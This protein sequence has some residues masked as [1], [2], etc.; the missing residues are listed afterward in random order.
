MKYCPA[1]KEIK[2]VHEFGSNRSNKSGLANHCRPCHSKVMAAGKRRKHGSERNYLLKLRYGVTEEEVEQMIAEQGGICVIC[3][4]DEPKHV[5]HDHMTGLVR[6]VLCFKCNGALGQFE[7][8]PERLRLAAEYLELDGSHARRLEL[9]TGA[10]VFGGP[11]R[12]SSDPN[13]R[14]PS[15]MAGTGRH[16]HLRRRYGIND[17]DAQWLLKM[18]VGYCAACFDYP[19]EHVD[20][21]HRTGAVRGI[22]CHGCNTGMGQLRDDPVA[23]RRAADYLT[24][25]LVKTVP[26]EDGGTRLSFTVPDIDPLNV[27]PG[28]WTVHWEADGRHRKAN[29]EFGVLI[30][31]PAWTG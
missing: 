15:P 12:V 28:G 29:P 31:G 18:Q 17:A 26:A 25:G 7:D 4:R 2:A 9:E 14:K 8:N 20:H 11:D 19:A 5:D 16:Y 24:G 21:D 22:A 1:C 30:G 10:R 23:L 27:P 3:L 13:W 6:R